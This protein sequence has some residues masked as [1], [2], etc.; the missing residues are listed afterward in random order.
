MTAAMP[1]ANDAANH[2]EPQVASL[3]RAAV[4]VATPNITASTSSDDHSRDMAAA[5]T[6]AT[7]AS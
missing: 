7:A 1:A 3:R 2:A 6:V 5:S 4:T